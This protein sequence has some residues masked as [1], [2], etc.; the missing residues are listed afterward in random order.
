MSL[1]TDKVARLNLIYGSYILFHKRFYLFF[2]KLL[3]MIYSGYRNYFLNFHDIQCRVVQVN[4]KFLLYFLSSIL[5]IPNTFNN[6]FIGCL[7]LYTIKK[8]C[9]DFTLYTLILYMPFQIALPLW[10][11]SS[12]HSKNSK[13]LI[14]II[15]ILTIRK[16]AFK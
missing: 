8:Y 11:Q 6:N 1:E 9:F 13:C 5:V 4:D 16:T 14:Y 12:W 7:W 3:S 2:L 10:N 15:Y